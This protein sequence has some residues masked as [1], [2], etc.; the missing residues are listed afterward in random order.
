MNAPNEV[1]VNVIA[2]GKKKASLPAEKLFVLGILA[3]MFIAFAAV[4]ANTASSVIENAGVSKLIGALLFPARLAMVLVAGSELFTGNS[5]IIIGVL[6]KEVTFAAMCK[7]W[8]FVYLGNFVGALLVAWLVNAGHQLSLFSNALAG[9]T[10]NVA[11]A[12]AALSFGDAFIRG[13]LCNF[14][15]CIAVWMSFAA[16]DI[17]GKII[18]LFFP[19][20]LFVLCGFEHSVANMYYVPAGLFALANPAYASAATANV[21]LLTWGNF[22]INNLIPVTLGNVVGGVGLV[23]I[24]YWLVY[25]KKSKSA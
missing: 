7:N 12:K 17:A 15:V 21:S 20:M 8:L 2:I 25:L 18:G 10:I 22:L 14:L 9:T 16:K 5:L 6:E 1:A 24:P 3:G 13:V 11:T 19:V 4:G 23:G